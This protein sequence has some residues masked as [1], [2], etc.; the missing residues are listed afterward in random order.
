[1]FGFR[2]GMIPVLLA[3]SAAGIALHLAGL[4]S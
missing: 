4:V 2:F 3:C 1:M